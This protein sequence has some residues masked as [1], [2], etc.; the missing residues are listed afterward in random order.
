[1]KGFFAALRFLT[2]LPLPGK[3]GCSESALTGSAPFFPLVGLLIGGIAAAVSFPLWR[4]F[5]ALPAAV[6]IVLSLLGASG[7]LHMDGLSDTADG[8][9]G[10][11]SR[12]RILEIMRDSRVG[13]MGVIAVVSVVAVKIAALASLAGPR[14]VWI[15]VLLMPVAGRC[16]MVVKMALLPYARG[17]GG[18]GTPFY[19]KRPSFSAAW[20]VLVLLAT[21]WLAGGPV[22][23]IA[24][25]AALIT[26]L[27]F[28]AYTYRRIGGATGDTLGASCELAE[29]VVA[30]TFAAQ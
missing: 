26:T 3:W 6:L 1:M 13:A 28:A 21:G 9:Q 25:G 8:F 4:V 20:A 18:L 14:L 27:L 23:A 24:G 30:L 2:V 22:G 29:A 19:E 10:S 12:E 7:G 16:A 15:A 5:P 11:R 17:E